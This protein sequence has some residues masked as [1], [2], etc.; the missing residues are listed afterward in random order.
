MKRPLLL[1]LA[2][3]SAPISRAAAYSHSFT[4]QTNKTI[5]VWFN[6]AACSNDTF[7]VKPGE[8]VTWRSGLCCM[9][10]ANASIDG[11]TLSKAGMDGVQKF[12]DEAPKCINTNWLIGMTKHGYFAKG[13]RY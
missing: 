8:V 6:Y 1:A 13:P 5:R 4:N 3:C 2:L 7:T 11:K 12:L 10:T 9:T